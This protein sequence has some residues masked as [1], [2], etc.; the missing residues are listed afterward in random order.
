LFG[1]CF[2]IVLD[3]DYSLK[4]G[5]GQDGWL[6][7][8]LAHL[9]VEADFVFVM[10]HHPSYTDSHDSMFGGGHS[11]RKQE[12]EL[13]ARLE[14]L[15]PNTRARIISVAGHVH[16][17]ERFEHAGVTYIV[18][19]GGG[20]TPYLFDRS[21]FDKF[22]GGNSINYNYVKFEIDGPHLKATMFRLD[23]ATPDHARFEAKDTFTLDTVPLKNPAI[24]GTA[25]KP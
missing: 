7:S 11:A 9:P 1:N 22:Q 3:S 14:A 25:A 8:Q 12:R 18:S 10:T 4:S 20:A 2:F 6:E 21:P 13:A 23:A 17:Y 24:S 16:N 5:K 19:G 15:Q